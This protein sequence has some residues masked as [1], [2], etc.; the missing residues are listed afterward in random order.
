L[1]EILKTGERSRKQGVRRDKRTK[2]QRGKGT[3]EQ[4]EIKRGECG[5]KID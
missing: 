3:K 2:E 1:I 5:E 4:R